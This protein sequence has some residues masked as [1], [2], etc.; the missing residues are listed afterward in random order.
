MNKFLQPFTH[1]PCRRLR[2]TYDRFNMLDALVGSNLEYVQDLLTNTIFLSTT[3]DKHLVERFLM[4]SIA[5]N[6]TISKVCI[7]KTG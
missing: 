1:I 3:P 4:L 7:H 6:K 5:N 2:D